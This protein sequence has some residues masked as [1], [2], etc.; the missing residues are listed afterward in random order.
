MIKEV[1]ELLI[2]ELCK[3]MSHPENQERIKKISSAKSWGELGISIEDGIKLL[4][5]YGIKAVL[6][7]TDKI[8]TENPRD[9]SSWDSLVGIHMTNYLPRNE[10]I[11]TSQS[12]RKEEPE[13]VILLGKVYEMPV[14]STRN[15]I[16]MVIN[17]EVQDIDGVAYWGLSK[18]AVLIPL[19]DIPKGQIKSGNPIDT[20]VE[21]NLQLNGQCWV[22]C[23]SGEED[24]LRNNNPNINIL[25]YNGESV[26]G[27]AA[28]FASALGY[29]V[30]PHDNTRWL[31]TES[32]EEYS[33]LMK[34]EDFPTDLLHV[35]TVYNDEEHER[36]KSELLI[37]TCIFIKEHDF[38]TAKEHIPEFIK[39]IFVDDFD[40][41]MHSDS[42]NIQGM[43]E[44][45]EK[46]TKSEFDIEDRAC[47]LHDYLRY[48]TSSISNSYDNLEEHGISIPDFQKNI[49]ARLKEQ[50]FLICD[51]DLIGI[52]NEEKKNT[53][54]E[55]NQDFINRVLEQVSSK[56]EYPEISGCEMDTTEILLL[57]VLFEGI[58][59][60]KNK[61]L[62]REDIDS[63]K[64][65]ESLSGQVIP[66][67]ANV[68]L[69]DETQRVII[70]QEKQIENTKDK[71][72]S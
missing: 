22:L 10:T 52:L 8:I 36:M 5:E 69:A 39:S 34:N 7:E 67:M 2:Q 40:I 72:R 63:N 61:K 44:L 62:K 3:N 4:R 57:N 71:Q 55:E 12:A 15:T 21:G 49:I 65:I 46:Y 66:E 70:N 35:E 29:R 32:A 48:G 54:H 41:S 24:T 45:K 20:F 28:A 59:K 38:I 19:K 60:S 25:G 43:D 33:K 64:I 37:Q 50:D 47:S 53:E 11:Y 30:E 31:N 56:V 1:K 14:T 16:H 68:Q 18:Y 17:N 23:P 42:Y 51:E 58:I 27:Y 9:Y 13:F 6:D 26:R